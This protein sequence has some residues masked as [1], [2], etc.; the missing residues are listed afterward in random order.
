M[1]NQVGNA[2]HCAAISRENARKSTGPATEEGKERSRFNAFRHA[3]VQVIAPGGDLDTA[4]DVS[5]HLP[6][7]GLYRFERGTEPGQEPWTRRQV[8]DNSPLTTYT[9]TV[10]SLL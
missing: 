1:S 6:V 8:L 10:S 7:Y 2:A 5:D 3:T 4:F 9:I